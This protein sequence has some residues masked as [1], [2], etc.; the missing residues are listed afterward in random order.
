LLTED[1]SIESV[2]FGHGG[3]APLLTGPGL[4]IHVV[5]QRLRRLAVTVH[6]LRGDR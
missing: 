3:V 2:R 6:E 4:G 5:E 1:V